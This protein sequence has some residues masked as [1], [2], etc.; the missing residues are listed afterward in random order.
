M[1]IYLVRDEDTTY[2]CHFD[3]PLF[4]LDKSLAEKVVAEH[5]AKAERFY[6]FA[7]IVEYETED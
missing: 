1:K 4:F 7:E 5:N 6:E 2:S 3:P